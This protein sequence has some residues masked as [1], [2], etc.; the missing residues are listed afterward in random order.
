MSTGPRAVI[1]PCSSRCCLCWGRVTWFWPPN[2]SS[3][4]P[5]STPGICLSTH[6]R[7]S[8]WLSSTPP[9]MDTVNR[10]W[11]CS[12]R[13]AD[14]TLPC[15]RWKPPL[16]SISSC[17]SATMRATGPRSAWTYD[18]SSASWSWLATL[19]KGYYTVTLSQ[20]SICWAA[21]RRTKWIRWALCST[22][23]CRSLKY[24]SCNRLIISEVTVVILHRETG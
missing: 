19:N 17:T 23:P 2:P 20:L 12:R 11:K 3:P 10:C 21:C 15:V 9:I 22:V 13:C 14:S 5:G 6:G 18:S 7:L 1:Q 16:W 24:C 4:L 8:G